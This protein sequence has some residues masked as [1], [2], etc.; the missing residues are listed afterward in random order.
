MENTGLGTDARSELFTPRAEDEIGE[1]LCASVN[2]Q[3]RTTRIAIKMNAMRIFRDAPTV[4]C[5][6]LLCS[7]PVTG[8]PSGSSSL[9]GIR[10][11][12]SL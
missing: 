7:L 1:W 3:T 4:A 9:S 11:G 6:H 10:S 12:G 2:I 5:L 8:V